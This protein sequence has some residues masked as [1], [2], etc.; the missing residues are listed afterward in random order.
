MCLLVSIN[1]LRL[2]TA[3][4]VMVALGALAPVDGAALVILGAS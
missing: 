1:F 3:P 4:G 2:I